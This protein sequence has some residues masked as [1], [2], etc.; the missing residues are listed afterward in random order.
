MRHRWS[1]VI[2]QEA[3]C[4]DTDVS[5]VSRGQTNVA[6]P[7]LSNNVC[8]AMEARELANKDAELRGV[9][10]AMRNHSTPGQQRGMSPRWQDSRG[11]EAGDQS[12]TEH[13]GT[14]GQIGSTAASFG[15]AVKAL[16]RVLVDH[17]DRRP[18]QHQPVLAASM[19]QRPAMLHG[20]VMT[21]AA[22]PSSPKTPSSRGRTTCSR[23]D[24]RE[25]MV[26][27]G[28]SKQIRKGPPSLPNTRRASPLFLLGSRA[29]NTAARRQDGSR[30]RECFCWPLAVGRLEEARR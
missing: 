8:A 25:M 22:G 28:K 10:G 13:A 11:D 30:G 16:A 17:G 1:R 14:C 27:L 4:A 7:Y 5:C 19:A 3:P 20:A 24:V 12:I 23:Q 2:N 9:P 21:L 15:A 6:Q 26:H 18:E 29:T